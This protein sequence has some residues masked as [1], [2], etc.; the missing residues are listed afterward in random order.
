MFNRLFW[1]RPMTHAMWLLFQRAVFAMVVFAFVPAFAA[2]SSAPPSPGLLDPHTVVIADFEDDQ[3]LKPIRDAGT[4]TSELT[5]EWASNGKHSLKLTYQPSNGYPATNIGLRQLGRRWPDFEAFEYVEMDMFNPMNNAIPIPGDR[6]HGI[7]F[8]PSEGDRPHHVPTHL[9]PHQTR[10]IRIDIHQQLGSDHKGRR[11]DP[12][13]IDRLKIYCFRP[14]ITYTRYL[15]HVRLTRN[16]GLHFDQLIQ[17]LGQLESL[18]AADESIAQLKQLVSAT[19]RDFADKPFSVE[20]GHE[21]RASV[22][23]LERLIAKR[24][25]IVSDLQQQVEEL[26]LQRQWTA[27]VRSQAQQLH[28]QLQTRRHELALVQVPHI[29]TARAMERA[30]AELDILLAQVDDLTQVLTHATITGDMAVGTQS[31]NHFIQP[32]GKA[33]LGSFSPPALKGARGETI[34]TQIVVLA[35]DRELAGVRVE[36][37]QLGDFDASDVEVQLIGFMNLGTATTGATHR[38][39]WFGDIVVPQPADGVTV[40]PRTKQPFLLSVRIPR[41]AKAGYSA[42][43]REMQ[44][45]GDQARFTKVE[46][47]KFALASQN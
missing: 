21:V 26:A 43:L 22:A 8:F 32:Y 20:G 5:D 27:Q 25:N 1:K 28:V 39:Q 17:T 38:K 11:I 23:R 37:A 29:Y 30:I 15:D 42:I 14:S 35:L 24:V 36:V 41:D 3:F 7:T 18:G 34:A 9:Q 44:N 16:L 10:H 4:S 45:K 31:V 33:M 6:S 40:R 2:T 19:R 46:R 12:S 47:G 13:L